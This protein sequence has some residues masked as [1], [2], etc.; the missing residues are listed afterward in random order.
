M[1]VNWLFIAV[2]LYYI[3][4]KK[5]KMNKGKLELTSEMWTFFTFYQGLA[6]S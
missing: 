5:K 2:G 6:P 1:N 3:Q 4:K